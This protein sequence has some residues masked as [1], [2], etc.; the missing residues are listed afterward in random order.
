MT[1]C[2]GPQGNKKFWTTSDGRQIKICDIEDQHLMNILALLTRKGAEVYGEG[3]MFALRQRAH[4]FDTPIGAQQD[5][6]EMFIE[7]EEVLSGCYT[8]T[9]R[10]VDLDCHNQVVE[11]VH[12]LGKELVAEWKRRIA[13]KQ[14]EMQR[15]MPKRPLGGQC[16]RCGG[17]GWVWPRK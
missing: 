6:W 7:P 10:L 16:P 2:V 8:P 1:Q 17:T 4:R 14:K 9:R 12:P 15:K 11:M 5:A 13:Q 3:F